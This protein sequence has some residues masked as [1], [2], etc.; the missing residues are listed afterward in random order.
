VAGQEVGA[1]QVNQEQFRYAMTIWGN[2]DILFGCH[3]FARGSIPT[4][5]M[6]AMT[7]GLAQQTVRASADLLSADPERDSHQDEHP[8]RSRDKE[9]LKEIKL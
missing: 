9:I 6:V 7:A 2:V 4:A 1:T 5:G 8:D 3:V